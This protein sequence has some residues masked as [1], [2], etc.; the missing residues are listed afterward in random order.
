V[1]IERGFAG[2][3]NVHVGSRVTLD[4]RTFRVVGLAVETGW[5]ANWRPQLVWV[6]RDDALRLVSPGDRS[7][8]RDI[9]PGRHLWVTP[10]GGRDSYRFSEEPGQEG[11]AARHR[12]H[13]ISGWPR[14]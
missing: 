2:Q 12:P 4:D 7:A 8:H 9:P 5:G 1:V 11:R 14:R 3:L 13:R 10:Q 6:T